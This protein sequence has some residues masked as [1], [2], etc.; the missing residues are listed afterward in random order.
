VPFQ[1]A[2]GVS[3]VGVMDD[4]VA[5][6]RVSAEAYDGH[7]G[8][9]GRGL[10]QG[11][12]GFAEIVPGHRVL[13]VGAGTGMLTAELAA[14]VG[15]SGSVTAIEPSPPFAA[16]CR[17][18]VPAADVREGRAEQLPFEDAS[19]DASLSQLVVNFMSDPVAG[20]REMQRVTVSGGVVA[21]SVW[22]YAGEMVLL[23]KFWDAAVA[24][25]PAAAH[26]DEGVIMRHCDPASLRAL[27]EGTGLRRVSV[28]ELVTTVDYES[29]D[30]LWQPFVRGVAP[31]GAYAASLDH[32]RRTALRQEY[33]A[34]LGRPTGQFTL[35]ARAWMIRG[36]R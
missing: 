24:V 26:L 13:D 9:Y 12:V 20:V 25:D 21:S 16:A 11:L 34:R 3:N 19:F 2:F 7:V 6:F 1:P 32:Q 27:W 14:T 4:G 36:Q 30:Q 35:S 17:A 31:S 15:S 28:D 10:A 29:F 5:T 23:R 18:R 22:D 8:R 33:F